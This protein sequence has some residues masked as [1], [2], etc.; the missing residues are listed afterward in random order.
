MSGMKESFIE[1]AVGRWVVAI[2][3]LLMIIVSC[4]G[5]TTVSADT[6][7]VS[8]PLSGYPF[9]PASEEDTLDVIGITAR[10]EYS[11]WYVENS[12]QYMY[13]DGGFDSSGNGKELIYTGRIGVYLWDARR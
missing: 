10:K 3:A 1:Q 4:S 12:L 5:C 7:H 6:M 2:L 11:R 13:R 9:G 8:R